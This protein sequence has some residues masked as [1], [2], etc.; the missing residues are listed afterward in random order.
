MNGI[1]WSWLQP[2]KLP[3]KVMS[4]A[5]RFCS[6]LNRRK[7]KMI[8]LGKAKGELE[9]STSFKAQSPET[10]TG[11]TFLPARPRH[12]SPSKRQSIDSVIKAIVPKCCYFSEW[13][14]LQP[15]LSGYDPHSNSVAA[16]GHRLFYATWNSR[17]VSASGVQ[18]HL[19]S[20]SAVW[21]VRC[22]EIT[23]RK[24]TYL[25]VLLCE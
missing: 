3:G 1:S 18:C 25:E 6:V 8:C 12:C 23:C 20:K 16:S 14:R 5:V 7:L 9:C 17:L 2:Q 22:L 21:P 11:T 10:N 4:H 19:V 13:G 15:F 24:K